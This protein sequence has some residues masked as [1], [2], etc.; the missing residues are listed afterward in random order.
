[1][2]AHTY[3]SQRDGPDGPTGGDSA[4]A[5]WVSQARP[6]KAGGCFG[7]EK[8]IAALQRCM[9]HGGGGR[10]NLLSHC[11][12][13]KY[14][15]QIAWHNACG[16]KADEDANHRRHSSDLESLVTVAS[17][18][19]LF[20]LI[21]RGGDVGRS[22][23][24]SPKSPAQPGSDARS[25]SVEETAPIPWEAGE[26]AETSR[27]YWLWLDH[28]IVALWI[29]LLLSIIGLLVIDGGVVMAQL[30]GIVHVGTHAA[31][32]ERP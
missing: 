12:N 16:E 8:S 23:R 4:P 7:A 1:M 21:R 27:R 14:S 9:Q 10:K 3:A 18:L 20:A 19:S 24:H 30:D 29:I 15:R 5:A 32:H 22:A 6:A 28:T 26:N 13:S 25:P 31:N 2:R 11:S 17:A